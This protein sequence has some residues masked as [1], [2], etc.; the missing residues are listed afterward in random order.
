MEMNE[1][2]EAF[3][4]PGD[5][6]A[7]PPSDPT[8]PADPTP[9]PAEEPP[10][11]PEAPPADP[12]TTPQDPPAEPP[13][14]TTDDK[15][16][17][18]FAQMRIQN[19]QYQNLLKNI[20]GVLGVQDTQNPELLATALQ[21]KVLQAQAKQQNIAP[22]LLNRLQQLE[23]RDQEYT[24]NQLRSQAYM[25]FQQVKDTFKLSDQELEGF[26]AELASSGMN[27]FESQVDVV[28]EY[29]LRNFDKLLSAA[30]ARGIQKEIERATNAANHSS[31]PGTRQ[32]QGEAGTEKINTVNDLNNWFDKQSK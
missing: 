27:P 21:E 13:K 16:S 17:Q 2:L 4:V 19:K 18:M 32:G 31:N 5:S 25:G 15:S 14:P 20:A 26:A 1:F 8:P 11:T 7:T 10:V 23:A 30:E 9:P 22:E 29:K 6:V 24:L 28:R 12:G 3:G